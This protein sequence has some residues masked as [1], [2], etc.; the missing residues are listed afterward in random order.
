M[1][2]L[3]LTSLE[4]ESDLLLCYRAHWWSDEAHRTLLRI[5]ISMHK[6]NAGAWKNQLH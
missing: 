2:G 5:T 4:Q 3:S 1:L 6:E